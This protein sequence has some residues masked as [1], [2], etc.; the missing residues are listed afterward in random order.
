MLNGKVISTYLLFTLLSSIVFG[1][2]F[3]HW[4]AFAIGAI[5]PI[6]WW[7]IASIAGDSILLSS[8]RANPLNVAKYNEIALTV[9]K[10]QKGVKMGTPSLWMIGSLAPMS[11]SIGLSAR[12]SHIILTRGFLERLDD[13]TQTT[14]VSRELQSI[15]NGL[16][17]VNTAIAILLWLILIPGKIGQFISGREPGEPN[18]YSVILNIIPVFPGWLIA[19]IGS[20]KEKAYT[21]DRET[22]S[23]LDHPDYMP[24]ALLQLQESILKM[25][26]NCE[27]PLIGCCTINPGSNDPYASLFRAHPPTPKR[28]ERLR[29]R[30]GS[31]KG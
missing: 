4:I 10:F 25:P 21:V 22:Q 13:K 27:L 30:S 28:I 1:W 24:Y 20:S 15:K 5:V 16:T 2:I 23:I 12:K 29:I 31:R 11:L 18:V 14:L 3:H 8:I 6:T 17:S 9:T 7:I 26:F 19:F